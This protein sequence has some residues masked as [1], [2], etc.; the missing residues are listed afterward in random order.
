M[1]KHPRL[2]VQ[3]SSA[4]RTCSL[5]PGID[6]SAEDFS[7]PIW[8]ILPVHHKI[9]EGLMHKFQFTLFYTDANIH[10]KRKSRHP[11]N[12]TPPLSPTFQWGPARCGWLFR[13]GNLGTQPSR[14][15]HLIRWS[16]GLGDRSERWPDLQNTPKSPLEEDAWCWEKESKDSDIHRRNNRH[17]EIKIPPDVGETRCSKTRRM[18]KPRKRREHE[19][20]TM[21]IDAKLKPC[22]PVLI[23]SR[24]R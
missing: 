4:C 23:Q 6:F 21:W 19:R 12:T 3:E 2:H 14:V 10:N 7:T 18:S 20:E 5:R 15:V 1:Q 13:P 16:C 11:P 9:H 24:I 17:V 22:D 8:P